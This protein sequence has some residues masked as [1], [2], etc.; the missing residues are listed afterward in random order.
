MAK[1]AVA[2]QIVFD[3]IRK[4]FPDS[5]FWN[6]GKE[7]RINIDEEGSPVQIKVTL[8]AAKEAVSNEVAAP[9]STPDLATPASTPD[10][11]TPADSNLST[12][13]EP[14]DEEKANVEALL[15]SLGLG[16]II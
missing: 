5:F 2:K 16:E 14:T 9:A 8:T 1:G 13:A 12:I 4:V 10:L 6:G 11:A 7:L 3:G 15:N